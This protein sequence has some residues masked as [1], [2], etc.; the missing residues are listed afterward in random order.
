MSDFLL[1]EYI[2]LEE[3]T[4]CHDSAKMPKIRVSS[5]IKSRKCVCVCLYNVLYSF[6]IKHSIIFLHL[7]SLSNRSFS[8]PSRMLSR[9]RTRDFSSRSTVYWTNTDRKPQTRQTKVPDWLVS[10]VTQRYLLADLREHGYVFLLQQLLGH[11]LHLSEN[12][13]IGR[14]ASCRTFSCRP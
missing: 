7:I 13:L 14:P 11:F 12:F 9:G 10:D 5:V 4:F 1:L 2:S 8:G 6:Y 3:F